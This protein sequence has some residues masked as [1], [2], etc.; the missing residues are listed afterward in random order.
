MSM[1][2]STF[3]NSLIAVL[4]ASVI[5]IAGVSCIVTGFDFAVGDWVHLV[6]L[7]VFFSIVCA[8]FYRFRWGN[9]VLTLL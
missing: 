5:S 2:R 9:L 3:F 1:K 7:C 6:C 4:L 8:L